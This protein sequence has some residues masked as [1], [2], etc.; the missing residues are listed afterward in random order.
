M[1]TENTNQH[2]SYHTGTQLKMCS[3]KHRAP[4]VTTFYTV[5][6]KKTCN[7]IISCHFTTLFNIHFT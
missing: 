4:S 6:N 3:L 1:V 2:L 5:K 7:Q